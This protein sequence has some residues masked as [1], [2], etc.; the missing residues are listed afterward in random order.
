MRMCKKC[1]VPLTDPPTGRPRDYCGQACRRLAEFEIR[2]L[3][4]QLESLDERKTELE[5]P[6]IMACSMRDGYGRTGAQQLADTLGPIAA[7]ESRLRALIDDDAN[8]KES[9]V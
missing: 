6:A 5:Q 3:V 2:R 1:G 9:D 8:G 7:L 4:R